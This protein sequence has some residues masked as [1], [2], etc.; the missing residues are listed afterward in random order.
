MKWLFPLLLFFTLIS[1]YR[2]NENNFVGPPR[3]PF[4]DEIDLVS[5]INDFAFRLFKNVID[6]KK[7]V[8]VL[9]S[10]LSVSSALSMTMNGARGSTY[11]AISSTLALYQ[12]DL[13]KV[14]SSFNSLFNLLSETDNNVTFHLASS[15]WCRDD[16]PFEKEFLNTL[17]KFFRAKVENLNFFD[18]KSVDIIN[19]WVENETK[20]KIKKMLGTIPNNAI[21]YLLNA[22]YF[23]GNWKYPFDKSKTKDGDFYITPDKTVRTK[24]MLQIKKFNCYFG[25]D[26]S[27]LQLPYGNGFFSM[28]IILPNYDKDIDELIRSLNGEKW[29]NLLTLLKE[30][31][32]VTVYLPRFKTEF[33]ISLNNVLSNMGM[34]LAFRPGEADFTGLC[35]LCSDLGCY[36][37]NVKHKTFIEVDEEGTTA[38]GST[39]VEISYTSFKPSFYCNRPFLYLIYER[40]TGGI[41]FMGKLINPTQS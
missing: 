33:E 8:N 1:C 31:E 20:G 18:P 38:A 37:S 19:S 25:K 17:Q 23:K 7:E 30:Q 22:I 27:A 21:M 9:V 12:M 6:E 24:M 40:N 36:I 26:Y 3:T 35:S 34:A 41:L 10:P 29:S 39:S 5:S 28:M 4:A 16:I 13:H 15:V 32:D 11:D 14:N 2:A